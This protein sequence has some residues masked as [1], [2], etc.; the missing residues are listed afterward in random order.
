[1]QPT[2]WQTLRGMAKAM[3][4][5]ARPCGPFR[6]AD[7]RNSPFRMTLEHIEVLVPV[8]P[9]P[10][11]SETKRRLRGVADALATANRLVGALT[12]QERV[13]LAAAVSRES[14]SGT[15]PIH[16]AGLAKAAESAASRA[17]KRERRRK[18]DRCRE[19]IVCLAEYFEVFR[20]KKATFT[21]DNYYCPERPHRGEF[22]DLV[23]AC[24]EPLGISMTD[25]AVAK[26]IKR[27]SARDK[28]GA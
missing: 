15:D 23:K 6:A 21:T 16:L 20:G 13:R 9:R 8:E 17:E 11:P 10:D 19:L 2:R 26:E 5:K 7:P 24:L 3:G 25:Q 4:L 28:I 27:V 18:N 22:F 1:M 14:L 12:W